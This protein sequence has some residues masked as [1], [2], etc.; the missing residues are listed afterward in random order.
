MFLTGQLGR[1]GFGTF[2]LGKPR[3]SFRGAVVTFAFAA[4]GQTNLVSFEGAHDPTIQEGAFRADCSS[5][6][7]FLFQHIIA[8]FFTTAGSC[9]AVFI[10]GD[11]AVA[12]TCLVNGTTVATD[13][14][15]GLLFDAPYS[16]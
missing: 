1:S 11:G 12:I 9:T 6:A 4:E 2:E 10:S 5:D 8:G 15:S 14:F 7:S 16:Y 3:S 13:P